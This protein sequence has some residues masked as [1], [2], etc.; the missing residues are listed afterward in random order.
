M[1]CLGLVSISAILKWFLYTPD[2]P[3]LQ[4][5]IPVL[6][7]PGLSAFYVL[8]N[9]MTADLVDYD[10]YHSGRR[11]EALIGAA[12]QW[13]TKLGMSSAYIFS[14]LILTLNGFVV[15]KGA[16][17]DPSTIMGMRFFFSAIPAVGTG[18][19]IL[20]LRRYPLDKTRMETVQTYL[21]KNGIT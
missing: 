18:L 19:A 1:A 11:R 15:E 4:F 6:H 10:E 2:Y 14:G 17:Q 3:Y 9:S 12:N 13:M 20:L 21:K 7:A 8:I 5:V 16:A